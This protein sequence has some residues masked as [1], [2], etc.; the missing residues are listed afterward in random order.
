[1]TDQLRHSIKK[2]KVFLAEEA[3]CSSCK[4]E[5][6]KGSLAAGVYPKTSA[7]CRKP[8]MAS[9]ESNKRSDTMWGAAGR[10]YLKIGPLPPGVA[11]WRIWR[12]GRWEAESQAAWEARKRLKVCG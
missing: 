5:A 1:M 6:E 10:S 3:C 7:F 2:K 9:K 12:E 8:D 11:S 4:L